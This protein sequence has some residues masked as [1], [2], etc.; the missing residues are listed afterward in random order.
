MNVTKTEFNEPCFLMISTHMFPD[1]HR[2]GPTLIHYCMYIKILCGDQL[3]LIILKN[4]VFLKLEIMYTH[5]YTDIIT[6]LVEATNIRSVAAH[7]ARPSPSDLS[8]YIVFCQRRDK[9]VVV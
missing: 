4:I 2:D 7:C 9:F 1:Q 6:V 8:K 5:K 3:I